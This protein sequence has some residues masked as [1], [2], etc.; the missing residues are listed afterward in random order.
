MR[1]LAPQAM[2]AGFG[3]HGNATPVRGKGVSHASGT[4][5]N[6]GVHAQGGACWK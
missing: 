6:A 4:G 3:R 2:T 1:L 5:C